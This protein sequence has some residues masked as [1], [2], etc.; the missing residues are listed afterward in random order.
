VAAFINQ[1]R[2]KVSSPKFDQNN[3]KF[4]GNSLRL[5]KVAAR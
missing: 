1:N 4:I 2:W 5:S 3:F